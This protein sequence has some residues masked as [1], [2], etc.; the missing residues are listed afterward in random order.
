M[1]RT[2][3]LRHYPRFPARFV[4]KRERLLPPP[5]YYTNG[6]H[7]S[8]LRRQQQ[9]YVS[10]PVLHPWVSYYAHSDSFTKGRCRSWAFR[11]ERRK[12]RETLRDDRS[13][14]SEEDQYLD[15]RRTAIW[16]DAV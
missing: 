9:E 10:N 11:I 5:A 14:F 1:S 3:R 12:N 6:N 2:Y 4:W 8:T 16:W 13:W 7:G 15:H